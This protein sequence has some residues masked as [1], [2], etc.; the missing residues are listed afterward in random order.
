MIS[1]RRARAAAVSVMVTR[2]H[3]RAL[4]PK[5]RMPRSVD[6]WVA[7]GSSGGTL[8]NQAPAGWKVESWLPCTP[9]LDEPPSP[10]APLPRVWAPPSA[11]W[12]R[13]RAPPP[14]SSW[15]AAA[16]R[17]PAPD[18]CSPPEAAYAVRGRRFLGSPAEEPTAARL[19]HG[20][21]GGVDLQPPEDRAD[22]GADRVGRHVEQHARLLA[23]V[24][25][26]EAPQDVVL[27]R[28]QPHERVVPGLRRRPGTRRGQDRRHERDRDEDLVG[29]DLADR[30][31]EAFE[32]LVAAHPPT[33]TDLER[34]AGQ[35]AGARLGH[36]HDAQVVNLFERGARQLE[37]G[38]LTDQR[39]Q[40][41][42]VHRHG[43]EQLEH[44][45]H[46]R[47]A[48]DDTQARQRL[49]GLSQ[50]LQHELLPG[51]DHNPDRLGR[52][53]P[54]IEG[55]DRPHT[56]RL[57]E[58]Q[59]RHMPDLDVRSGRGRARPRGR[60]GHVRSRAGQIAGLPWSARRAAASSREWTPSLLRRFW[61]CVRAVLLRTPSCRA[62]CSVVRPCV[63]HRSTS[64]SRSVRNR[65]AHSGSATDG[66]RK[67]CCSRLASTATWPSAAR[68]SITQISSID[69]DLWRKPEAPSESV[70]ATACGSAVA[71]KTTTL[72][73]GC[74]ALMA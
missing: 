36:E 11:P 39:M 22:V 9:P 66:G 57:D 67:A 56:R 74:P 49:Q 12:A 44:T 58:P 47:G 6:R 38:V 10:S 40:D 70:P 61:T 5:E 33:D 62:I 4:S 18:T 37:R 35:V 8:T 71:E 48:P 31:D 1:S 2:L 43:P 26:H 65:S 59:L 51:E 7:R 28:G 42:N 55:D 30:G 20:R 46:G 3:R 72:V 13:P 54:S 25:V 69:I 50:R 53:E 24:T 41:Q 21:E 17:T 15:E 23:R 27:T 60:V 64:H 32:R 19:G 73:P 68:S 45:G 52:H 14:T 29:P 63:M 34:V 16:A